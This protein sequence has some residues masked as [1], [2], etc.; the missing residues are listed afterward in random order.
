MQPSITRS[1][2]RSLQALLGNAL[3][4]AGMFPPASLGL[5][6]AFRNYAT[7]RSGPNAW[8]LSHFICPA[9]RLEELGSPLVPPAPAGPLGIS[10][11]GL[12]STGSG[13][14][15]EQVT[16]SLKLI[17]SFESTPSRDMR[18]HGIELVLPSEVVTNEDRE[19]VAKLVA[20]AS[21]AIEWSNLP[22]IT[23]FFEAGKLPG[24]DATRRTIHA[25]AD[26]NNKWSGS[27]CLPA[28]FKLRTGG[29]T[30]DAFPTVGLVAAVISTCRDYRV[31]FKC[32]AGLHHP[33]RR[34]HESVGTE[35]H[36][37]LN[38]LAAGVLAHVRS[39]SES[40][41]RAILAD[42]DPSHFRFDDDG[43]T[44][45]AERATLAEIADA[46]RRLIVSFGS[47]NVEEPLEDLRELGLL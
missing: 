43:L 29:V 44:W 45:Q 21:E 23:P 14:F 41:L 5:E 35:M 28:A 4:Y 38:V 17:S 18:V 3:D 42:G 13:D 32:T 46:R 7:H 40:D 19:E 39:A 12:Q 34:Y 27:R 20:A 1:P 8:L 16:D 26:H 6:D 31:P 24:T 30:A 22:A 37:F 36:G 25:I 11:L 2:A 15:V 10:V 47:C 33:I 9:N